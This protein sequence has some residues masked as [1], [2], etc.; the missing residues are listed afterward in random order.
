MEVGVG[1]AF[2]GTLCHAR[3]PNSEAWALGPG[4]GPGPWAKV[5]GPGP[6]CP[7]VNPEKLL[8]GKVLDNTFT[9][10]IFCSMNPG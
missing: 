8:Q 4:P 6:G 5:L 10:S 7:A 3:S 1:G 2:Q 9:I